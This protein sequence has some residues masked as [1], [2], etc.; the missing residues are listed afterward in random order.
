MT[1]YC[2]Y[3]NA[4]LRRL[5]AR[6][7]TACGKS[8]PPGQTQASGGNQAA[9]VAAPPSPGKPPPTQRIGAGQSPQLLIQMP[10][11]AGQ[12]VALSTFPVILGSR[13]APGVIAIQHHAIAARHAQ[14]DQQGLD[15]VITDLGSANGTTING[16]KLTP[17]SP[18]IL[19]DGAVIRISDAQGNSVGIQ[20][21][22]G[23]AAPTASVQL[24]KLQLDQRGVATLGRD[25]ANDV[26]LDHPAVSRFHV[27]VR[28]GPKGDILTD[29]SSNGTFVNGQRVRGQHLLKSSDVIQI[30][31]FKLTY[32]QS[33]LT[34]AAPVDSFRLDGVRLT[35]QVVV[36]DAPVDLLRHRQRT[37]KLILNN[38]SISIHPREFVALVGGSGAGKSTLMK[39]LS[40][41]TPVQGQV[42]VNG[43]D[44]Y[45]NYGAYRSILGYVPQ[46][47]IIHRHLTVSGALHYAARLRLPDAT[48]AEINQR[49]ADVLDQVEMTAHVGK[50]VNALSGGQ[51]KRVSIAAELLADPG[52]FFLDEPTSG[53]DPG[54]EK[55]MMYTLRRLAD[56][57]RTVILVTHA[58]ANIDQCDHVAFLADGYL[59]FFGPPRDALT[60]FGAQDF[61]DIYTCLTHPIDAVNNPPPARWQAPAPGAG[62][63][64]SYPPAAEVWSACYQGSAHHSR[65]IEQRLLQTPPLA[66]AQPVQIATSTAGQ[67]DSAW[68]QF[69]VLTQRYIELVRRDLVSLVTLLAVMPII[70]LLLLIMANRADLTGL[71]PGA[72][73]TEIQQEIDDA[74]RT[75]DDFANDNDQFKGVYQVAGATQT[76]LF[77]LALAAGLLGVF[78]AAYEI[79]REEGIY[80]RERMVN[81]KLGP[82]LFSKI[83]VLAGFALVQCLLLLWV[84]GRKVDYPESGVLL[85]GWIELYVTLFLASL[86]GITLGLLISAA[87]RSQNM[88]IYLILLAMFVQILFAGAIFALPGPAA[89]LS[90]ITPTRWTLEA[91]GDTV[92]M[93][94]LN[95]LS[96]TCVEA[97][98]E[99][100]RRMMGAAEAPCEE[101]QQKLATALEFNVDYA[102]DAGHLLT[103]WAVLLLLAGAFGGL[104]LVVQQ[105]KDVV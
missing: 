24:G 104:T 94:R 102:H 85:P 8:L 75:E 5:D 14:I 61:A 32:D 26:K 91:L 67:R 37:T 71:N 41:F 52:L 65:Y 19:S 16:Q 90:Y 22:G 31:P 83:A 74:W 87:V 95:D 53:L 72:I 15:F 29:R 64:V 62:S 84:V 86:T 58:T 27:E 10:G 2:P 42:L 73:Y 82:Y 60:F 7:C 50:L 76:L 79:V 70:G 66:T 51:R 18:H 59:T 44:L 13:A 77:M 100:Q 3:C 45:Q 4:P 9:R 34:Q 23:A 39:A 36:G 92:D 56:A 12:V 78:G 105:R 89:A 11:L 35:R 48:P 20:F 30:G 57:G 6:F 103:R 28:R 21:R 49:V 40:G 69:S 63:A 25:P 96:V 47:D 99:Q 81:L 97:E 17:N 43:D 101:G 68:R 88:V 1:G 93:E 98:N 33:S 55:K 80:Q 38:I 46:D 54:L